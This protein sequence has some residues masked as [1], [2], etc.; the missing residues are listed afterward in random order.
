PLLNFTVSIDQPLIPVR[1]QSNTNAVRITL[2]GLYSPPEAWLP[3]G[4][5][6]VY[7]ATLPIPINDDKETTVVFTNGTLR[8]AADA[9]N[10]QKRWPDARGI[11][12]L[13]GSYMPG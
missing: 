11:V 3:G 4:A 10:K 9:T 8:A 7:T 13:N 6:F 1:D 5:S 12:T 2:E